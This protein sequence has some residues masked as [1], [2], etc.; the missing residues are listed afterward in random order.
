MSLKEA[1]FAFENVGMYDRAYEILVKTLSAVMKQQG[2]GALDMN[3]E[4]AH[5]VIVRFIDN[6]LC[7]WCSHQSS[8]E[9]QNLLVVFTALLA[10]A[11]YIPE[12]RHTGE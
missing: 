1:A 3:E 12:E 10:A 9:R 6:I 2:T 8:E 4:V 7:D 5:G 11:E